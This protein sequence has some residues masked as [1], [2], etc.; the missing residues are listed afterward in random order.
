MLFLIYC[1]IKMEYL[2]ALNFVVQLKWFVSTQIFFNKIVQ[3]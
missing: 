3:A 2:L 1:K